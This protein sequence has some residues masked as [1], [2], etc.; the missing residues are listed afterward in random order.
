MVACVSLAT[1]DGLV[2]FLNMVENL[3]VFGFGWCMDVGLVAVQV[4][5]EVAVPDVILLY[6]D[7]RGPTLGVEQQ[8]SYCISPLALNETT[9]A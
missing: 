3:C 1:V 4:R 7:N 8:F 2:L 5:G 6:F 9:V